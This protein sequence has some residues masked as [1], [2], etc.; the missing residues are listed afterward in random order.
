MNHPNGLTPIVLAIAGVV[1][2]AYV[3]ANPVREHTSDG[4]KIIRIAFILIAI[5]LL[6]ASVFSAFDWAWYQYNRRL[7][8]LERARVAP[9]V[10]LAN[11]LRGLTTYQTEIVA[12]Q[13][14]EIVAQWGGRR[15]GFYRSLVCSNGQKIP[16]DFVRDYLE[17]SAAQAPGYLWPQREHRAMT[18]K[19]WANAEEQI[20]WL[21]DSLN[22]WGMV[23][24]LSGRK[25]ELIWSVA[26]IIETIGG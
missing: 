1:L 26:E 4:G 7:E 12:S 2:L 8:E 9:Q 18:D 19:G 14:P 25:V 24:K 21:T 16:L 5:I 6:I 10:K 3:A 20:K 15:V 11:A 13:S 17:L 23:D 22:A